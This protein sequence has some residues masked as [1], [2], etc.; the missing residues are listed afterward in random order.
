MKKHCLALFLL[1]SCLLT[2]Q[3]QTKYKPGYIITN[4][5]D[6]I[7]GFIDYRTDQTNS[8]VCHFKNELADKEKSFNPGD[9]AGYRFTEAGKYYTTKII[10]LNGT[11][12]T[13]FLEYLLQGI[14][15]LYFY[16]DD[17]SSQTDGMN[18]YF[19]EN[20]N[21]EFVSVKKIPDTVVKDEEG[22]QVM[23]VDKKFR[24]SFNYIF[25]DCEPIRKAAANTEFTHQSMIDLTKSYHHLVCKTG[26]ECIEFETTEDKHR[27]KTRFSFYGGFEY[28]AYSNIF[29][30]ANSVDPDKNFSPMIGAQMNISV[31]R[32]NKSLSF[33]VDLSLTKQQGET[34]RSFPEN[35][36]KLYYLVSSVNSNTSEGHFAEAAYYIE[37][38]KYIHTSY[39]LSVNLG[40]KY[41]YHK[42]K[43]RPCMEAGVLTYYHI[44][45]KETFSDTYHL[46]VSEKEESWDLRY[47]TPSTLNLGYY[48]ALGVDCQAGNDHF[49]ICRMNLNILDDT[50]AL[51]MKL[52]YTF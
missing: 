33:Q 34:S 23:N 38:L 22:H 46:S 51:Q 12:R 29:L 48:A 47:N 40:A 14:M 10:S 18:Y 36:H 7:R 20:E 26:E 2:A 42:G 24:S 1:I 35:S 43:V 8:K 6:T 50:N 31:P 4:N 45:E 44:N 49:I 39:K 3:A 15:N 25:R 16:S 9:I 27:F 17:T 37:T 30:E 13:V 11:Q 19:F 28:A 52:G 41:T 32:L 5:G 21:G